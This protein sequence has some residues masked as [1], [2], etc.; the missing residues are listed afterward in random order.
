MMLNIR[1]YT[2][3]PLPN[4]HHGKDKGKGGREAIQ[5]VKVLR[6]RKLALWILAIM[7][8]IN[9]I[10]MPYLDHLAKKDLLGMHIK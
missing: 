9:N 4:H 8:I 7:P 10:M 2:G 3:N 6:S 5:N 1:Q